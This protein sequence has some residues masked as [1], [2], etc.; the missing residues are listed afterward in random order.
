MK[1]DK[2][3]AIQTLVIQGIQQV[4]K[5]VPEAVGLQVDK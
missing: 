2:H 3:Y 5:Y 4:K 1:R